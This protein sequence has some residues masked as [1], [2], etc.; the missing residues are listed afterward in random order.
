MNWLT[1]ILLSKK[2]MEYQAGDFLADPLK[3]KKSKGQEIKKGTKSKRQEIKKAGNQKV[4]KSKDQ[5][6]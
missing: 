2:D 3:G 5:N 4:W 1:H 6:N